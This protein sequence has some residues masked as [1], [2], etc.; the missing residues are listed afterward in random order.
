MVKNPP[1][2]AGGSRDS[3]SVPGLER[4]PDGGNGNPPQYSCWKIPWAGEPGGLQSMDS[5]T[6][7]QAY[8]HALHWGR[9][10]LLFCDRNK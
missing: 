10:I 9:L 2:S 3:G 6:A 5:D 8:A 7:E 4:S 1:A